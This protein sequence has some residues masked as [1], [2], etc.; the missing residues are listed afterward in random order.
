MEKFQIGDKVKLKIDSPVMLVDS[1]GIG[2]VNC[3]WFIGDELKEAT[4]DEI[5]LIIVNDNN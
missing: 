1:L 2:V 5:N 4:F 3:K